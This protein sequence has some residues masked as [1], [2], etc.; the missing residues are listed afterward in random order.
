M[1][2]A[3]RIRF[4]GCHSIAAPPKDAATVAG[5]GLFATSDPAHTDKS[6]IFGLSYRRYDG[7]MIRNTVAGRSVKNCIF[8]GKSGAPG[9]SRTPD[10]LV[11]SQ[12][13]YPA[14]LRARKN[15]PHKNIITL[16]HGSSTLPPERA[17][18]R[19]TTNKQDQIQPDPLANVSPV[20]PSVPYSFAHI[21]S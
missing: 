2:E 9:E 14:E 18:N 19:R 21:L 20:A 5:V 3:K 16:A 13:L 6:L 10:L 7:G 11:R 15:K 8:P 4:R 12:T 17:P 1:V